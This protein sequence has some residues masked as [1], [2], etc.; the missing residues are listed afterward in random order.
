MYLFNQWGLIPRMGYNPPLREEDRF[1][2]ELLSGVFVYVLRCAVGFE[3]AII[4]GLHS[5]HG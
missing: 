5:H 1:F 3:F 4:F 2:F